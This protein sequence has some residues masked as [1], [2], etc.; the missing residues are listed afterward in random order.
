MDLFELEA[1]ALMRINKV[2]I[3][4]NAHKPGYLW[5]FLMFNLV[6]F[7]GLLGTVCNSGM[8]C[9]INVILLHFF[10][11][12]PTEQFALSREWKLK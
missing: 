3:G 4:H 6:I 1:V 8:H 2:V 10:L 9:L 12:K 11:S 5:I 7:V